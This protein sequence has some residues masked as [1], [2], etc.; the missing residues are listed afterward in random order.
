MAKKVIRQILLIYL[1]TTGIFLTI[2]FALWYQKLYEELVVLKGATLRENHR[3]I[4][5][6]ILNSRFT[7]IDI[8]AKNIA[9]STAL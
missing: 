9:Q 6:S 3:N 5:I 7:P 1:T 2:F 8:S 4:V